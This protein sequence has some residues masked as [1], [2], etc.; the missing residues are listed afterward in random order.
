MDRSWAR[1]LGVIVLGGGLLF[2][3]AIGL[4]LFLVFAPLVGARVPASSTQAASTPALVNND[5]LQA[6][7]TPTLQPSASRGAPAPDFELID[8][9]GAVINLSDYRGQVVLINFW[10]TW[11]SPCRAEMPVLQERYERYADQGLEILAVSEVAPLREV[12][13]YRLEL[14]LSFPIM[15]DASERVQNLYRIWSFPTSFIVD[16]D[17]IIR[18]VH[19]GSMWGSQLDDYLAGVGIGS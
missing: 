3:L 18:Y 7:Q 6:G 17:G 13:A 19:F 8:L 10:A 15:I 2:G 1:N 5:T 14:G 12:M 4:A 9:N 11:C 16:R